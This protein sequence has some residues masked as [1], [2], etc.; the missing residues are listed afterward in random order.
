MKQ[1][2]IIFGFAAVA[3]CNTGIKHR[4]A[5]QSVTLPAPP[6][7]SCIIPPGAVGS[8][9]TL[10]QGVYNSWAHGAAVTQG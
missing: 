1:T 3:L 8:T 9:P 10:S 7:C 4:L 2:L 5:Q 6:G